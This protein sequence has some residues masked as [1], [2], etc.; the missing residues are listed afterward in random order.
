MSLPRRCALAMRS[1]RGRV[2]EDVGRKLRSNSRVRP[3]LPTIESS[4][5]DWRPSDRSP[6]RPSASTT[7]SNGRIMFTSLGSRRRRWAS[8]ATAWW[9]R[10]RVKSFCASLVGNP[11]SSGMAPRYRASV[12]A[13][14]ARVFVTRRLPG[15][16]VD[17]LAREHEVDLWPDPDPPPREALVEHTASAEALLSQLTDPIDADLLDAAPRLRAIAN[18]AVGFDNIDIEAATRPAIPV[19]NTPDVLPE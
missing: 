9:R 15:D 14:M 17:R 7:S 18:Y 12:S 1:H 4:G 5:I 13:L 6:V 8:L 2:R 11:V 3:T 10:A 16:A 19:G